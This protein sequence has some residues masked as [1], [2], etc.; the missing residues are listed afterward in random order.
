[1]LHCSRVYSRRRI[2]ND[3]IYNVVSVYSHLRIF[4]TYST[5]RKQISGGY[6]KQ[7]LA[8]IFRG[9]ARLLFVS[10]RIFPQKFFKN[11]KPDE[12]A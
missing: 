2:A 12:I 10:R 6:R 7:G 11:I 3:H 4:R 8:R 9:N 5:N 1:M